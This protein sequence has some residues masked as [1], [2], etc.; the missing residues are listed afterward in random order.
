MAADR[1]GLERR[2]TMLEQQHVELKTSLDRVASEQTHARELFGLKFQLLESGQTALSSK[3]DALATQ[4]TS[5]TGDVNT[6]PMGRL[7]TT[8]VDDVKT[9][10]DDVKAQHDDDHARL[11]SIQTTIDQFKGGLTFA[12]QTGIGSVILAAA[13]FIV[14]I[15]KALRWLP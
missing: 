1:D 10:V 9:R 14:V 6:S 5:M 15:V 4:I 8:R 2:V 12:K 3:F 7:L 13:A 11:D